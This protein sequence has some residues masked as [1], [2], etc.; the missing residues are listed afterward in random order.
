VIELLRFISDDFEF[1]I[2]LRS[3]DRVLLLFLFPFVER[4]FQILTA[5]FFRSLPI[6]VSEP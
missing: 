4:H 5:P 3:L 1:N 6:R 2:S